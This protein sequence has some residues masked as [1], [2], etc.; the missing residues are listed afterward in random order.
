MWRLRGTRWSR[1]CGERGRLGLGAALTRSGVWVGSSGLGLR[2]GERL[3]RQGTARGPG[4]AGGRAEIPRLP[5]GSSGPPGGEARRPRPRA[6]PF[7]ARPRGRHGPEMAAAAGLRL[8]GPV[9][10]AAAPGRAA[11]SGPAERCHSSVCFAPPPLLSS[12]RPSSFCGAALG[13]ASPPGRTG[14]P[15]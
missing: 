13:E 3:A 6:E 14:R 1:G 4:R 7:P 2:G 10:G 11:G 15:E 5:P 8:R 9:S 12:P